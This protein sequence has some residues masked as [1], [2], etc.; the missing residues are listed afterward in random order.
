MAWKFPKFKL[1]CRKTKAKSATENSSS[2]LTSTTQVASSEQ[3]QTRSSRPSFFSQ[4]FGDILRGTGKMR[5]REHFEQQPNVIQ[6]Q[7]YQDET[8]RQRFSE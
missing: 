6:E 1:F 5:S 3:V 7:T 2:Q 4:S 8:Y